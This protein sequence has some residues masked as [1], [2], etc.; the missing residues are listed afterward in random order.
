M[1]VKRNLTGNQ[2]GSKV[3][4]LFELIEKNHDWEKYVS[5]KTKLVVKT[6]YKNQN[7]TNTLEELDMKYITARSHIIRAVDRIK[8]KKTDYL[9]QGQ[10]KQAQKLFKLMEEENWQEGLTENEIKLAEAFKKHKS[11]YEV[12]RKFDIAPSNVAMTLYGSNQKLGVISKI[13]KSS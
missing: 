3:K 2:F 5:D 11:F 9:R 8:E 4:E 12:G 13:N 1:P 10:S 7:M 6:L